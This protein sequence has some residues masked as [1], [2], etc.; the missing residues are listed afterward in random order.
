MFF[1]TALPSSKP[2]PSKRRCS[3]EN[4]LVTREENKQQVASHF[5]SS[6]PMTD[7]KPPVA[8]S[9]VRP[10]QAEQRAARRTPEPDILP[11]RH[12]AEIEKLVVCP[13]Q[14]SAKNTGS[15]TKHSAVDGARETHKNTAAPVSSGMKSRLQRLAEQR[16]YLESEGRCARRHPILCKHLFPNMFFVS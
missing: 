16:Q 14:Y 10:L 4:T 9:S 15:V 5:T 3:D 8:P 13:P 11:T 6:E 12:P 2:S 1:G 7:K